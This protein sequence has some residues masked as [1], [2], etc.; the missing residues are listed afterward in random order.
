MNEYIHG[1]SDRELQRLR[2]QAGILEELLH[3]EVSYYGGQRVLEVGCGVGAQTAILARRNPDAFFHSVDISPESL[4]AAREYVHTLGLPNVTFEQADISAEPFGPE[5]FDHIFI[6]FVLEHLPNVAKT[7]AYLC[8][9]L[10]PGG[11]ITVIEGDHGASVWSPETAASLLVWESM[12]RVQEELGHDPL[13]GRRLYP[14]LS[15][16][17]FSIESIKPLP[18][19]GDG[20]KPELLADVVNKIIVPMT[21]TAKEAAM[22][23]GCTD[24]VTWEKGIADLAETSDPSHGSFFYTWFKAKGVKAA[25]E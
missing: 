18:V 1:Y 3:G 22:S 20:H 2:E 15:Q 21:E 6:C 24:E 17:G 10:T 25:G 8:S 9:I 12:I 13:I 11:T 23:A 5:S 7:L 19:Y 4:T 16:A 14:L